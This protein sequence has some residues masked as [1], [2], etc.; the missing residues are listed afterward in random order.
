MECLQIET[1]P[2][3]GVSRWVEVAKYRRIGETTTDAIRAY[4]E[5]PHYE[6]SYLSAVEAGG[7]KLHGPFP[8]RAITPENYIP[9]SA[10][11]LEDR[12]HWFCYDYSD[13]PKYRVLDATVTKKLEELKQ[14]IAH[15][16]GEVFRLSKDETV[17]DPDI[18]WVLLVFEEYLFVSNSTLVSVIIGED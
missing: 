5:S 1:I 15:E 17:K 2:I 6:K 16:G 3:D 12:L 9:S 18:G 4:I 7:G 13:N 11:E 10:K 8:I 14:R